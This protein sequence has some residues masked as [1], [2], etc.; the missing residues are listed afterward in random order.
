MLSP[1]KFEGVYVHGCSGSGTRNVL[2]S[3]EIGDTN[4]LPKIF[5]ADIFVP[6]SVKEAMEDLKGKDAMNEEMQAQ[7][8]IAICELV[9]LLY[10]KKTAGSRWV[11]TM[12]LKVDGLIERYKAMSVA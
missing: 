3:L 6:S 12:K 8:K 10:G 9:P 4:E 7:P 1:T 5:L 11:Y 2:S